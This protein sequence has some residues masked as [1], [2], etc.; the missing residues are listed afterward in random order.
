MSKKLRRGT[1]FVDQTVQG[2]LV[3]RVVRYW[4][5]SLF[6]VGSL[7]LVGWLY[8]YPG[9]GKFVG[10][11]AIMTTVMPVFVMALASAALLLPLALLDVIRF[12]NRIAGPMVRIRRAM[13]QL[14][15]E[16]FVDP[17]QFREGD[18]WQDFATHFNA[19]RET[20]AASKRQQVGFERDIKHNGVLAPIVTVD[21]NATAGPSAVNNNAALIK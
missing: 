5:L 13:Q 8:V 21:P 15:T 14:A 12:S 18:F 1:Q 3:W 11:Y 2:A 17:L 19:L 7:T 6:M 20:V 9:I 4:F 16:E 10:Q